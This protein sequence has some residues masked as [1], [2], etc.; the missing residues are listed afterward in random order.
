[1]EDNICDDSAYKNM[2][3]QK[4]R[5]QLMNIPPIR[6]DNLA[7][8]P[9]KLTYPGTSIKFTKFDLDMRRKVEILKY[10][11]N[12][13]ST[14]TNSFTKAELYAQAISGK[15]QQ[16]TYTNSFVKD[17]S[18]NNQ[19]NTCPI[20][21]TPTSACGV[22]GPVIYLYEDNNV[23][24]YNYTT[25]IDGNYGS[26]V[27]SVNPYNTTWDYTK[28]TNITGMKTPTTFTT[29]ITSLFIYYND[30]PFKT[31]TITTPIS[32]DFQG[33]ASSLISQNISFKIVSI[34][35]NI[36]YN[37]ILYIPTDA[38][39]INYPINEIT[40]TDISS[41][42]FS[43]KCFLGILEIKNV[44]L[45]I[46]KGFIFDIKPIITYVYDSTSYTTLNTLNI[47]FNVTSFTRSAINCKI[48]GDK[49]PIG[50]IPDM[51]IT[52]TNSV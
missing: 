43:G 50:N 15:Y 19:L 30:V 37:N 32:I 14:Q 12:N 25:N 44:I 42:T 18:K 6:Y 16:R 28:D 13:S 24:V 3:I 39:I 51:S 40:I 7:N 41:N 5:F 47:T 48:T 17:N 26:L 29:I 49:N 45:P 23:P 1:M 22:P 38:Y 35:T 52:A 33:S 8:N 31:F 4:S 21:K 34:K 11:A 27:Q 10:N 9:Y 20:I 2:I 36:L 46:Q